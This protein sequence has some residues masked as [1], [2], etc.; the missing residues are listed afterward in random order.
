[1]EILINTQKIDRISYTYSC[2]EQYKEQGRQIFSEKHLLLSNITWK[3]F[4]TN[5]K[6][7]REK[8]SDGRALVQT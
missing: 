4:L 1:M 7:N 5:N 8:D 3:I 6:Q 2:D